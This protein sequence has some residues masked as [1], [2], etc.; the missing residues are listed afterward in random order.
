MGLARPRIVEV[1]E[2]KSKTRTDRGRK[3]LKSEI[4]VENNAD[5]G[6]C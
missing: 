1:L 5:I 3:N 2:L 6:E 4:K